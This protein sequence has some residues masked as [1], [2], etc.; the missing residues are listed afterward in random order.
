[1]P[2]LT[3]PNLYC[4]PADVYDYMGTAGAQ[5]RLDDDN[6]ATGYVIQATVLAAAGATSILVTAL[7]AP[8]LAGSTLEF[9]GSG[10]PAVAEAVLSAVARLGDTTLTVSPLAAQINALATAD[11]NGVN[12]ALAQRLVKACQYGTSRVKLYC[13]G[14][15]NDSDLAQCWSANRWAT[16][17][18]GKWLATRLCRPCPE[19][20]REDYDEAMEELNKVQHHQ[21]SL[22]DIGTRTSGWPFI[23]NMEVDVAY[24]VAKVRVEPQ[25]SE[26]TPTQY[27]QFVD[28][29][30]ALWLEW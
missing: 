10:M 9:R 8:L 7:Q 22:E 26:A 19:S 24:D 29:N 3:L 27:G 28:W 23:S 17:L 14:R 11:D 5:L 2:L 13:T 30:S 20:I 25:I 12:T 16:T 4:S 21:L 6:L 15:Y 18:A 1:M